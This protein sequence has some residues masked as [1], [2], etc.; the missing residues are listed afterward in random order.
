MLEKEVRRWYAEEIECVCVCVC[1]RAR[2]CKC[3]KESEREGTRESRVSGGVGAIYI[4][5]KIDRKIDK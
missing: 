4:Y 2:A 3:P 5:I 1:A